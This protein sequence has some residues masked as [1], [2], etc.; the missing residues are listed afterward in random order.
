MRD[1]R[2]AAVVLLRPGDGEE[3][4][5]VF[6]A[7]RDPALAF[8][9]GFHAFPGGTV[10]SVDRSTPVDGGARESTFVSAACRELF[11]E[12][13]VL[14]AG[15]AE[16]T[17]QPQ[18]AALRKR[19]L[20]DPELW[21]RLLAD[22]GLEL[23]S[24]LLSFIG[25]WV[26]PPYNPV[27]FHANYFVAW[28]PESQAPELW[29]GE[30]IDGE[31]VTPE[32]A[33]RRH[34]LGELF[35]SYPVLETFRLLARHG[36]DVSAASTEAGK[37]VDNAHPGGELI[38]GVHVVP[39]RSFTLPPAT[40]TNTYVLGHNP[41]VVV[42]PG[43]PHT[44]EH[45][46][47]VGFLD[48]LE[49]KVCEIWLSH[50]H[51]D[52]VAGAEKLRDQLGVPIAAHPLTAAELDFPI[53]REIEEDEVTVLSLGDG[54]NAEWQALHTPGHASGHLCFFEKSR[55]LLL[56]GDNVVTLSTVIVEPPDGN[57][58]AYMDTLVRLHDLPAQF[59]FPGHG[60]PTS[61]PQQ[62]IQEYIDHRN[63]RER[64]ILAAL[65]EPLTPPEI[66]PRV[67]TDVDPGIYPLA[68]VNVRAHLE[69]LVAEGRVAATGERFRRG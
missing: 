65:S 30:L 67:Y 61:R 63:A 8:L 4:F 18:R 38:V 21:P 15:G 66:V 57:M 50:H 29:P 51:P 25:H 17:S 24:E 34:H 69:K 23:D 13:G 64:A 41:L 42:D 33:L 46:K 14:V 45:D 2:A 19:L 43:T 28:L 10:E 49:G 20:K 26:T 31:W 40:T 55:G 35:I 52:H 37:R 11:E 3:P 48:R 56:S 68:E 36:G 32:D 54:V 47:L 5:E 59:L 39:L 60:P 6:L 9:G 12:T 22:H 58:R 53:D 44:D 27:I 62:T 16:N 7:R 1:K